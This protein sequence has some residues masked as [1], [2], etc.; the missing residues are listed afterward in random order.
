MR[1]ASTFHSVKS[2]AGTF[3]PR[4][5]IK[6]A[7][8]MHTN[9]KAPGKIRF[10]T[11]GL[12]IFSVS[13]RC[14]YPDHSFTMLHLK[15][16]LILTT[17]RDKQKLLAGGGKSHSLWSAFNRINRSFIGIYIP[18]KGKHGIRKARQTKKNRTN[19]SFSYMSITRCA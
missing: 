6:E 19:Q 15:Q 2:C 5:H 12:G 11:K 7:A 3:L 1:L 14:Q 13:F 9:E 18:I 4:C 8:Y 10:S 17:G 16:D